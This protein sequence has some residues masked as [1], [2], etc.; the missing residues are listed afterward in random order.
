MPRL[1]SI[2]F[3]AGIVVLLGFLAWQIP[4]A[5]PQTASQADALTATPDTEETFTDPRPV[6]WD[7]YVRRVLAGGEGLEIVSQN[8]KGGVFQAY[9]PAG[10]IAPVTSGPVHVQG[11]WRGYTCAYGGN[12]S[13]DG[14][15]VPE[16]DIQTIQSAPIQLEH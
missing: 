11:L 12:A 2:A 10:Q 14:G 1:F 15:C 7:G 3:I 6:Q 13:G 9:M 4:S 8:A 5:A 16:V